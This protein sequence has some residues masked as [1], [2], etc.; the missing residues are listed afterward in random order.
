MF[1]KSFRIKGYGQ[2]KHK[3]WKTRAESGSSE[4]R[5]TSKAKLY[6]FPAFQESRLNISLL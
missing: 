4:Q 3:L 6:L 1:N 5:I 2:A